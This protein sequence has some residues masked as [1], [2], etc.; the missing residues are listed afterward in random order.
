MQGG[1]DADDLDGAVVG[2]D[3]IKAKGVA[4]NVKLGSLERPLM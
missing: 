2:R 3:G 4:H 1:G